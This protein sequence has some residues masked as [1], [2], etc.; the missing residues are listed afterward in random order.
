MKQ[1]IKVFRNEADFNFDRPLNLEMPV[2]CNEGNKE[3]FTKHFLCGV[4]W[5]L[6]AKYSSPVA[7]VYEVD[8][9]GKESLIRSMHACRCI[10][11]SD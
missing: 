3:N 10:K 2:N 9:N 6:T 1:I 4:V 5:G 7:A 8:D 11:S